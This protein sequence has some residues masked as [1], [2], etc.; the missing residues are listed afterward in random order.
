MALYFV[1]LFL[2]LLCFSLFSCTEYKYRKEV[3]AQLQIQLDSMSGQTAAIQDEAVHQLDLIS[4]MYRKGGVYLSAK[5]QHEENIRQMIDAIRNSQAEGLHPEDYHLQAIESMLE[6]VNTA[7]LTT[8]AEM[9]QLEL[10]LTDAFLTLSS[11]LAAGKT[12]AVSADPQWNAAKRNLP[13][14]WDTYIDSVLAAKAV[15]S[16]LAA[17]TPRHHQYNN[18][19]KALLYYQ[20]LAA[21][22]GWEAFST[23]EKKL[24]KGMQNADVVALR[25]RLVASQGAFP[26]DTEDSTFFDESLHQ[27]VVIFQT[28]HGL[29][30]DGVLGPRTIQALNTTVEDR[31]ATIEANLERWR[32]VDEDLGKKHVLVNIANFTM[33]LYENDSVVFETEAIVGKTYRKTPVFSGMMNH[34]VFN[35]DWTVPPGIMRNDVIPA[36]LKNRGYLA[37]KNMV[38]LTRDGKEVSPS[39]VDW[40]QVSASNFPYMVRQRPGKD[41]ALGKVKFMFPNT[42]NVYIH[43]T[44]TRNLFTQTDRSFSSGCIR[45]NQPIAFAKLLLEADSSATAAQIDQILAQPATR[46]IRLKKHIPVHI[47]YL[48]AWADETGMVY[49]RPD[50]YERDVTL[51]RALKRSYAPVA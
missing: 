5:W 15:A 4:E 21:V 42:H 43:D 46:T 39:Q 10:L 35:P 6:R 29:P 44:P 34:L 12:D 23:S 7:D 30:N 28:R 19:R 31:I 18:L 33:Q 47:L 40:K 32:W 8:A 16:S 20:E 45:I 9:A 48:T 11:H 24:Q 2:F 25:K 36:I 41:N 14:Q 49:F 38:L 17:L 22:G 51:L 3:D 50:L 37:E 13:I 27:Q 26:M 1:R